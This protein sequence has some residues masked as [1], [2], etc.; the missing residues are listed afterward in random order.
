MQTAN[1]QR[2]YF[3]HFDALRFVAAIVIVIGHAIGGLTLFGK[4]SP[5]IEAQNV[6]LH[7]AMTFVRNLSVGVDL[8]FVLSGFL[9]TYLLLEEKKKTGKINILHFFFRR[10]FRIWPVFYL[11]I[12]VA[13]LLVAWLKTEP[14]P[15]YLMNVLFLGNFETIHANFW[16]YPF[17]HFWSICIEEHFY[18]FWPFVIACIPLKRLP[19]VFLS[20]VAVSI[21][22]RVY[23]ILYLHPSGIHLYVN[24][25]SRMDILIFGAALGYYYWKKPFTFTLP[26]TVRYVIIGLLLFLM[27]ITPMYEFENIFMIMF[28]KYVFVSLIVLLLL[29]FQFRD[30]YTRRPLSNKV[31]SYFGKCSYGIYMYGN[32]LLYIIIHKVMWRLGTDNVLVFLGVNVV[33]TLLASVLSYELLEKRLI[34]WSHRF[35]AVK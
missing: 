11:L 15:N 24:T 17:T 30:R 31:I 21:A 23:A 16:V 1:G 20:I 32:V 18:L 8:F 2:A 10:A 6:W 5:E 19:L 7:Y 26:L 12:A 28:K 9:I 35:R 4:L 33:V 25:L 22:F 29:D 27:T 3:Q 14:Q 34:R 13:P